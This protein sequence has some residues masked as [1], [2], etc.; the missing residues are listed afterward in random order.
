MVIQIATSP[1]MK[2]FWDARYDTDQFVYGTEPNR[3]L[4]EELVKLQPGRILLPGEGEGRNALFAASIGWS[5]D[6]MDQSRT[7]AKKALQ[8]A[9]DKNLNINYMVSAI[10]TFTFKKELYDVVAPVFVHLAPTLRNLFHA[11]I[12]DALRP[13]GK[14][15]L[16]A[17]HKSQLGRSS[18]GPQSEAMLY[19]RKMLLEDFSS[20]E[21]V[22]MQELVTELNEGIFHRGRAHVLRYIGMKPAK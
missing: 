4:A 15:I 19:D 13:G 18:G 12:V 2:E 3:F 8:L 6:A 14:I 1:L 21:V 5:V 16:E 20:L 10:E 11:R 7:A 9:N 22:Q 17:F